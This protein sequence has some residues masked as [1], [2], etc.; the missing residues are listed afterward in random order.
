MTPLLKDMA[1]KDMLSMGHP[2]PTTHRNRNGALLTRPYR[3]R[4]RFGTAV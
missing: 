1:F 4:V 2:E 3:L